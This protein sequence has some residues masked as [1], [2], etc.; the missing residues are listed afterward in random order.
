MIPAAREALELLHHPTDK[1]PRNPFVFITNGG[2]V[3]E[4]AKARELTEWLHVPVLPEQVIL[5]HTPMQV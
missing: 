4:A 3:S 1:R 2:G 5:G